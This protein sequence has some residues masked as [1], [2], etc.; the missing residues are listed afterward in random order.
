[1]FT[2]RQHAYAFTSAINGCI[3]LTILKLECRASSFKWKTVI[4]LNLPE[5]LFRV[6]SSLLIDILFYSHLE[7]QQVKTQ[8]IRDEITFL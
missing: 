1:M 2:L 5:T 7:I 3:I 6:A 4:C 8:D